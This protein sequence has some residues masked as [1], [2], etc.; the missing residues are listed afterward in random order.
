MRK[1]RPEATPLTCH[2]D[3][4]NEASEVVTAS[5]IINFLLPTFRIQDG[6]GHAL[7]S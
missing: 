7:L 6:L 2:M 4:D 1:Q 3:I 5:A